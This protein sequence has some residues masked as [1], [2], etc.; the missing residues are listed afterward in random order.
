MIEMLELS[1]PKFF[2]TIINMLKALM[3]KIDNMQEQMDNI[4]REMEIL[5][6]NK[7]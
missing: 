3:E 5:R 7:K 4:S 6:K 2:Y 1:D